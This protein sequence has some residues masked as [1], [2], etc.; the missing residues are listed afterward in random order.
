MRRASSALALTLAAAIWAGP[1]S[2]Q[3]TVVQTPGGGTSTVTVETDGAGR[4]MMLR[5]T[6]DGGGQAPA[7]GQ[8]PV[9]ITGTTGSPIGPGAA[10]APAM[11]MP[12]SPRD[13][14]ALPTGT[15][16]LRGRVTAAD[17]GRPLRRAVVRVSAQ[18]TREARTVNTDQNGRWELKDIPAGSY[19]VSANRPGF[20][21]AGYKQT[22]MTAAPRPVTVTDRETRENVDV[23]LMPGG[24][25]TGRIV[26]EFGDPV[27]EAMVTAQR[28]EFSGGVRRPV[29]AG[30]PSSSNDIGEFRIYGLQPGNYLL[31]ASPRGSLNP[32]DTPVDRVGYGQTWY[33]AAADVGNAQRIAVRAGDTVSGVMIALT[34][35]RT[36][37]ISG[38]VLGADDKPARSGMVLL[39]SGTAMPGLGGNAQV[40]PDGTFTFSNVAPGQYSL[41]APPMGPPSPGQ[42]LAFPTAEVTVNGTDLD[43]VVLQPQAPGMVSGRLVGDAATLASIDTSQVRVLMG[44]FG[45]Q[46]F[47]GGPPSPQPLGPEL[48]FSLQ[49]GPGTGM[50]R[51]FGASGLLVR[52]VRVDG[53]DASRGIDVAAGATLSD[54]E[55][56]VTRST[57]KMVVSVVNARGAGAPEHDVVIFPQDENAWGLYLPGHGATGRT[58]EDG[59]FEATTLLPG[60][61]YVAL[62]D[63][64]QI[65][66]GDSNDPE[67]LTQLRTRAQRVSIGDGETATVQLRT[68][69]R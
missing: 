52:S 10:G 7:P 30:P 34:P 69:E 29:V 38:T 14:S 61:Y 66:L 26:D 8:G 2:A 15:S 32:F 33:P 49:M 4:T 48:T 11:P 53:R 21:P 43:G 68:N 36:A 39:T 28:L 40:R 60:A 64:I 50:I 51:L 31:A 17:T 46:L 41:R 62:A 12:F 16:T 67:V 20:V 58:N 57:A 6:V 25:I 5:Q 35:A 44:S 63:D 54:V 9:I 56:E 55:V 42:G 19:T 59:A 37:R 27:S 22:R 1:A 47:A 24:V 65:D 23:A 45:T 13:A 3:T 18:S